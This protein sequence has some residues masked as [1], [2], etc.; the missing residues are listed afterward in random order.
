MICPGK[1]LKL[2]ICL[3]ERRFSRWVQAN[4]VTK[5][6]EDW[7]RVSAGVRRSGQVS[8]EMAKT[9]QGCLRKQEVLVKSVCKVGLVK[10]VVK[11]VF[12]NQQ[13]LSRLSA[14]LG[15]ISQK[16]LQKTKGLDKGVY[17]KKVGMVKCVFRNRQD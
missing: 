3:K 14:R 7:S 5:G 13:D 16:C 15:R 9:G 2:D 6:K 4:I 8:A 10:S 17:R 12:R 11:S 1:L